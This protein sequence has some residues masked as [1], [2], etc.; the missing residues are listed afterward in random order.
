MANDGTSVP[1]PGDV[2]SMGSV[3]GEGHTAVVTA[4]NVTEG[5]G[6][7]D[8]LEQNMDGG[9]GTN[10]LAVAANVV[11][12]DYD[13]VVTGWLQAI[14]PPAF[15]AFSVTSGVPAADLVHD[16]GFNHSGPGAWHK[17]GNAR[18]RVELKRGRT[19]KAM[20]S[21]YEGNGFA[22]TRTTSS[23]G[24]IYQDVAFPVTT[25]DSFC[26]DAEVVSTGASSGAKGIMSLWLL[27]DSKSQEAKAR[28]GPLRGKSRWSPVSTCLTATGS[29][30]VI[31]I[32]FYDTPH[33]S[34]VGIDAVDVHQSFVQ[35][36]GF[37]QRSATGWHET[38]HAWLGIES[39]G[40]L[41]T[42]PYGG[43]GFAVT[44][45]SVPSGGIYQ[46]VSLPIPAGDS[47]S[48]DA[49]VVTAGAH[50]GARGK[51]AL[52]L[53]GK[54]K[55]QVS[56][57]DFGRLPA[58]SHWTAVSTC[59][60][61]KGS[62]SG[63]RVQFY[64]APKAPALAIDAVDVHQSFV[65]DGGFNNIGHAGW[66]KVGATVFK[67]EPAGKLETA[68]YEGSD[69]AATQTSQPGG[70]IYQ[71]VSLPITAGES[72]CADAEVV[73]AGASA[74]AQGRMALT[75]FGPSGNESS[76]VYFGP[77]QA[78]GKWTPV[79][80]CVTASGPETGFRVRF[81]DDPDTPSLGIDAVDVR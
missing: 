32:Q 79:S 56:F 28:F 3:W 36:G 46:D 70:G 73:T 18:F 8:I 35:N 33:T 16:G 65:E 59:V 61:A 13:M 12:P 45:T 44:N 71:A 20:T 41:D 27:G 40:K 60:T 53:L 80:T 22:V 58:K 67:I 77:L 15:A 64:D 19:P 31:R 74:G 57:V 66:H 47:L 63:L 9:N 51:M 24:G 25:G 68:A 81:Y 34:P 49:E 48:A 75:F 76:S 39:A 29:H 1:K 43:G 50:P 11:E 37:E 7:I 69:F 5:Y 38:A 10:T 14:S 72:L 21:P 6:S 2:L 4:V 23:G 30:S 26:A 52:W 54:S 78:E 42:M 55:D 62:H 17:T